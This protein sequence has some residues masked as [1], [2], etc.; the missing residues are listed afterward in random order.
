MSKF[1]STSFKRE[2]CKLISLFLLQ[3]KLVLPIIGGGRK[4]V[5]SSKESSSRNSGTE[6]EKAS[7]NECDINLKDE[8]SSLMLLWFSISCPL[9]H[10]LLG[11]LFPQGCHHSQHL[12]PQY[13]QTIHRL[14]YHIK[15]DNVPT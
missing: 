2:I 10:L 1:E 3:R 13:A 8:N 15:F 11:N 12:L 7:K 6:R 9:N 5:K 14:G 4:A